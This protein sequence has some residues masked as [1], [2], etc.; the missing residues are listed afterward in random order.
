M[1]RGETSSSREEGLAG[2][3]GAMEENIMHCTLALKGMRGDDAATARI[4]LRE[5]RADLRAGRMYGA[6]RNIF[7]AGVQLGLAAAENESET[8]WW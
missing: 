6:V 3:V 1:R 7:E 8:P 5:A 4:S 2:A